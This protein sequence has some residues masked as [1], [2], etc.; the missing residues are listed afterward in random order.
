MNHMLEVG[1]LAARYTAIALAMGLSTFVANP[2]QAGDLEDPAAASYPAS[3]ADEKLAEPEAPGPDAQPNQVKSKIVGGKKAAK[4]DFPYQ[5][6]IIRSNAPSDNP[7]KG[8]FCGGTLVGWHWVLTAAHC[9]F[10]NN[11]LGKH[12]PGVELA[13]GEID[14]Y[15]GSVDFT[16]GQR[17]AVKSIIRNSGYDAKT[18]DND[19][20]LFE[21][22]ADPADRTGLD[23]ANLVSATASDAARQIPGSIA[24]AAGWGSTVKGIIPAD[25]RKSERQLQKVDVTFEDATSCNTAH[26]DD[27][28]KRTYDFYRNQGMSDTEAKAKRDSLYPLGMQRVTANM[29]CAGNQNGSGDACF[30]DSGGPLLVVKH[31]KSI[32]AGVVSWGPGNGCAVNGLS[33]AY[34][35]LDRYV[36][37]I[38]ETIK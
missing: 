21:L 6:A 20:A 31:G 7:F 18:K 34:V 11:P 2:A 38:A 13:A 17:M 15:L 25:Q 3:I 32:Q 36:D 30:G 8:F 9:T 10:K 1:H 29:I 16:G 37:W 19:L 26:V 12:L 24:T 5:V 22:A 33:G 4:G 14:V 27:I 35:R 23:I 28:R